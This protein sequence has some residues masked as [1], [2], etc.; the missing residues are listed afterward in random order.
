MAPPQK[1]SAPPA[2]PLAPPPGPTDNLLQRAV[3][4][5]APGADRSA[6]QDGL[7]AGHMM[8]AG[9][10]PSPPPPPVPAPPPSPDALSTASDAANRGMAAEQAVNDLLKVGR[11]LSQLFQQGVAVAGKPKAGEMPPDGGTPSPGI[12][13]QGPQAMMGGGPPGMMG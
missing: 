2:L 4:G 10:P 6:H 12:P 9:V 5:L 8:A 1:K 11:L 13:Q 3:A 7:A